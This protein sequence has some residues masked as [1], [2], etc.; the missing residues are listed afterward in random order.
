MKTTHVIVSAIA[1]LASFVPTNYA[2][3]VSDQLTIATD[4]ST[5]GDKG[6]G[7]PQ[8]DKPPPKP[9]RSGP[10]PNKTEAPKDR[11]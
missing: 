4:P 7:G 9:D 8:T 3:Q 1:L 10:D 5:K 11:N 2:G 6:A